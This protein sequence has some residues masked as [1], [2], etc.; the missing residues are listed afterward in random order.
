M[1]S[2]VEVSRVDVGPVFIIGTGRSGTN[3]LAEIVQS[4][5]DTVVTIETQPMFQLVTEMALVPESRPTLMPRLV[6]A[7]ARCIQENPGRV[8]V[9]KSHPNLWL[10]EELRCYFP[11]ARFVGIERDPVACVASMLRHAGV[12]SWF[13]RW[14]EFPIPNRFLGITPELAERYE[15]MSL[16]GK[17]ALRWRAH[18]EEMARVRSLIPDSFLFLSYED[19]VGSPEREIDK[20]DR[21]IGVRPLGRPVKVERGPLEKW[22]GVLSAEERG[23]IEAL[24]QGG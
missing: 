9:D 1:S 12:K 24:C 2:G 20:V 8:Y 13:E 4:H 23:V 7:Y 18:H 16:V 15:E 3:W 17:C 22:S 5:P 10:V 14:R 21:F 19:L 6:S 11:S